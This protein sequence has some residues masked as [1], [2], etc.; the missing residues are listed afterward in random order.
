MVTGKREMKILTESALQQYLSEIEL[1]ADSFGSRVT[2]IEEACRRWSDHESCTA[3]QLAAQQHTFSAAVLDRGLHGKGC[4]QS[5]VFHALDGLLACWARLS[6]LLFPVQKEITDAARWRGLRGRTLRELLAVPFDSLL[7]NRDVR[8]AWMHFD[9]RLDQ[10]VQQGR[11]GN[12][13][14]MCSSVSAAAAMDYSVRVIDME[15]LTLYY[16]KR[17]GAVQCVRLQDMN[18]CVRLV[19]EMVPGA[20]GR[21]AEVVGRFWSTHRE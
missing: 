8:D 20:R 14:T 12:R 11:L 7:S 15:R 9:E 21:A 13:Q 2:D 3:S 5:Q 18:A 6:L 19:T 10:A 16:R 1:L 4:E 17:D